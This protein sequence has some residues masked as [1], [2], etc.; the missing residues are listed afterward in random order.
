MQLKWF[1]V[2]FALMPLATLAQE[3]TIFNGIW[4][5]KYYEDDREITR[6]ELKKLFAKNEEV[7][8]LWKKSET[9]TALAYAAITVEFGFAIW[10]GVELGR[11]EDALVPALGTVGAAIIATIFLSGAN[12]NAR[13]AVLTYNKQFDRKTAYSI[14]PLVNNSGLGIALKF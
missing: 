4:G 7:A 6:S 1:V 10:T 2:L 14:V 9:N 12:K 13:K 8:G 3:I 11:D 5:P